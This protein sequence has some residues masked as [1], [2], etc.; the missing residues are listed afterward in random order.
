MNY[1]LI[2]T[3]T[4]GL[5]GVV[6]RELRDLGYTARSPRTGRI[7]FEGDA[8]AIA[9][10]NLWL[11]S[12]DRLLLNVARFPARD[13]EELFEGVREIPWHEWIPIDGQF[14][15]AGR[16]HGSRLE[17]VPAVQRATKKAIV[18]ALQRWHNTGN[19]AETGA[20]FGVAIE[21][22]DDIA[23]ITMNS[24]GDGLHKRGYR[25]LVGAAPLRETL[26]SA[27]VDL[28]FWRPGRPFLDPFCGSGTIAIEAALRGRD[29]AP[30][31]TR[32]F[33]SE[34]WPFI[35]ASV[36]S[37]ARDEA[38][39]REKAFDAEPL[40]ARDIDPE[41]ISIAKRHAQRAGVAE[42]IRFEVGDFLKTALDAPYGNVV[43]NPPW[44]LRLQDNVALEPLYARMADVFATLPTWSFFVLTPWP[45]FEDR[46][47]RKADRRRKLYNARVEC[48]YFQFHGPRPP[49]PDSD[50]A[51][52]EQA[53]EAAAP[54]FTAAADA[55]LVEDLANRLRKVDRHRRRWPSRRGI[56]SY[57]VYDCDLPDIPITVERYDDAVR[58]ASGVFLEQ[59]DPTLVAPRIGAH[60]LE[61]LGPTVAHALDVAPA[62]IFFAGASDPREARRWVKEADVTHLVDLDDLE[63]CGLDLCFRGLR[64]LVREQASKR[65]VL[66]GLAPDA[67]VSVSAMAGEA[68][69]VVRLGYAAKHAEDRVTLSIE[70]NT[71]ADPQ[72]FAW[73]GAEQEGASTAPFDLVFLH[74]EPLRISQR[75]A[76]ASLERSAL[77]EATGMRV[78]EDAAVYLVAEAGAAELKRPELQDQ[79][80]TLE[81]EDCSR[82]GA[83]KIARLISF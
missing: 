19:L 14:P 31:R 13:F 57:R 49:R 47:R 53:L 3:S 1:S 83:M 66:D 76:Q 33:A 73:A 12:A 10:S 59:S 77:E 44:G 38:T 69:R 60:R 2:A 27:L 35:D 25:D 40:L 32:T 54:V 7:E 61:R 11:R 15:V 82:V 80:A 72:R 46:V 18:E 30:G 39:S 4:F 21:L 43:T 37:E 78:A 52:Q 58:V 20:A 6:I 23:T 56:A 74:I 29:F 68:A 62:N 81:A 26:A 41:A 51:T 9:R 48:T 71:F 36:W 17:S 55:P 45:Q 63:A 34:R 50:A 67:G 24:S 79:T 42:C 5:E 28:S 65:H 70:H 8:H 75:R 64:S 22:V 16:S